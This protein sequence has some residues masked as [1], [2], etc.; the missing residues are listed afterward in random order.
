[1]GRG[2]ESALAI[3]VTGA[4]VAGN[5]RSENVSVSFDN[6]L[7]HPGDSGSYTIDVDT[8]DRPEEIVGLNFISNTSAVCDVKC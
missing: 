3:L 1:M 5:A 6:P 8:R 4:L 2:T 7:L